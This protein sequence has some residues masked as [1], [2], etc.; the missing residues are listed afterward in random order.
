MSV[1]LLAVGSAQAQKE[2][3]V[4]TWET[5][6]E[7]N[8]ELSLLH[9]AVLDSEE[10]SR[11]FGDDVSRSGLQ[12]TSLE[13]EYGLTDRWTAA[14]YLDV[15]M[16]EGGPLRYTGGRAETRYRFFD[17]YTRLVEMALA[18]EVD[19]PRPA[20]GEAQAFEGRLILS[21]DL[22][23][24]RVVANPIFELPITGDETG[25][26][27]DLGLAAGVYYRRAWLVQ[28]A[29]EYFAAFGPLARPERVQQQRHVVYP[30]LRF[31]LAE[32]L[33]VLAA[34]G[35]GLGGASDAFSARALLTYELETV[36][37]SARQH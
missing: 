21:R 2:D 8:V 29:I 14:L 15:S 30:G 13:V 22:G 7:A 12:M 4:Y 28:P 33:D 17:R 26:G 24:V 34:V 35:L 25:R 16:P 6:P 18:L 32:R 20:S 1:L 31:R 11:L 9:V 5:P 3:R 36:A 19:V 10:R 23:D 27:I 37:P